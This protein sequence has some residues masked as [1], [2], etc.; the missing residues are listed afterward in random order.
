MCS[1]VSI[2]ISKY[3]SRD[4]DTMGLWDKNMINYLKLCGGSIQNI[5]GLTKEF[6][7]LYRT[8]WEIS[9][10]S[11][12]EMAV[13][14]QPFVDQSQSMNLFFKDFTFDKFSTSQL[15]AWRNKLKTGSYYVR[16][17]ASI[18]PQKFTINPDDANDLKD[19]KINEEY[20]RRFAAIGDGNMNWK[21]ILD[22]AARYPIEYYFVEQDSCYG[23]DEFDCL[24]RSYDFLHDLGLN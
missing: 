2:I 4:L 1:N 20:K 7:H 18:A 13:D 12:M 3:L 16:T 22:T 24:R 10:K 9:Q 21:A 17:Q 6:K 19:F 14:R 5:T 8:S 23:A 15:F 11:I